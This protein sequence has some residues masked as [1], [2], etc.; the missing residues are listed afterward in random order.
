MPIISGGDGGNIIVGTDADDTIYG[1]S[2]ADSLPNAGQIAATQVASGF[3]SPV[4]A[5]SAPGD[6][7]RL[8]IVEKDLGRIVILDLTTGARST[9]LSIPSNQITTGGEQGLLSVAFHPN[10]AN[11]GRFYVNLVNANGDVEVR[12]YTRSAGNP[13]VANPTGTTVIIVP[14]PGQTN[15]NGGTVAFG[16]DGF[17]Y[18]SIGDGGGGGD[19]GENAQNLNS[20]L[21]KILR[22]EPTV[23]AFPGDATRNYGI[24]NDN[25]FV[26]VAGA[27]EIWAYGLRNPWRISFDSV[28]GDL[29]IGDVGQ[30]ARE[31]IDFQP[32][33]TGGLNYGWDT[34]EGTLPYEG[35]DSP[36]FTDPIFEYPRTM[37]QSVT[38]GYVYHGPAPG[39][40][41]AYIFADFLS[42]RIWSLRVE[43]GQAV[44]VVER[45]AQIVTGGAPLSQ[46]A[47]FGVDGNGALYAISLSGAIYRL[48]PSASAGDGNDTISA[49]AG[50]DTITGGIGTDTLTGGIGNDTFR[51]TRAGLNGDTITDFAVGDRIVLTD[52]S[53]SGFTFTLSGNTLTYTGGSL[54]LRG[55]TGQLQA[56]AAPEGGVQLAFVNGD[57]RN[58]FNGDG[59]SD[60][61]LRNDNGA[62]TNWLGTANGG[63]FDNYL[64]SG[65]SAPTSWHI[66]GTGD[67]NG[68]GR[69][70]V[71]W[72]ND[73]G[74][75]SNWLGTANGGWFDNYANGGTS[76]PTSWHIAGTGDFN[77]DGRDDLLLRN[78]NGAVTSWLGT[79]N[80]GWFDNYLNAGTSA[81]TSWHI[82]ATGDFNG[83]GRDDIL[84]RN[85]N[86][87]ITSWLGTANGGWFD[88]YQNAGTSAPTSWHIVGT[89]DFNGDGRDDI[90]L[91]N[92]NGAVTNWLGTANGGWFDNYLNAGTS[93]PTSWHVASIGDFNGDGRDDIL[94]RNDNGAI[95]NWLGTASGGWFDNYANGGT[96]APTS[97][98]V[99]P[100]TL[101][102]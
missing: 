78:D 52:A 74:A 18:I 27:D 21:G 43:N 62:I 77:G 36:A 68:D 63:W 87:A 22:I 84:F 49:G 28:T 93:A 7:N 14:H 95:T 71:V 23:D 89:G 83:D 76:A 3:S 69:D 31:E 2:E 42:N 100:D 97:W 13:D 4:F 60:V 40:Q 94:F 79:A 37:G 55:G 41:G 58:D 54:T 25:P 45:T 48:T 75:I 88:N 91:R 35:A 11:N 38:G 30:S 9:F 56:T 59:R 17:L 61:L 64:N 32:A 33:G 19:P 67:F 15:H 86:G 5:T 20:L 53:L 26:G 101:W 44:D 102:W 90:L 47:S 6:P 8:F 99:Q 34:R 72:R 80:G 85:D 50:N 57:V 66:A 73:N 82:A 65:T 39:L 16:P 24:P 10:Y 1:H 92:D 81:P 51:D 29:Y 70:D 12:G 46:I 98:H 96:S